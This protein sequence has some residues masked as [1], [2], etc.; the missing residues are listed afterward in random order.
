MSTIDILFRVD[1]ICK[2]YEKYDID[3]QRELNA[4]GDDAFARLLASF[5]SQIEAALQKSEKA[6]METNRVTVV[7]LNAEI[8]IIKVRLME[9]V[10]KLEKLAKKKVK[11]LTKVD[12]TSRCDMVL[13][14][15][16][17]IQAIPDGSNRSFNALGSS[18]KIK[19]DTDRIFGDEYFQESNEANQFRSEHE[20]RK[21]RQD[22]GLDI[23]SQGLDSLKNL[24][25][26]MNE[27]LDR[28]VPLMDD[29]E[30]KVDKVTSDLRNT[31]VR[32]KE[33]LTRQRE[34]NAYGD[35]AFARLLASFDY[36]IK[37]ALQKSEK[38]AM[39]T[40]RVTVVALNAEIRRIKVRLME[41]V[42]KLEK[43]AK[44]KVKGLI[45]VDL[46]SRCDM[47]LALPERIQ[48]IPDG[49][50][51]SFNAL[52]SSNKIK[53]DTNRIFGDEYFQE[54]NEANQFRSEHEMRKIRQDEGLDIISQGLD[55][56][57]NLAH[58]MNEEL[59]RQ[60]PLM[61]DI[62][63]KVDKVTSNLRNT[64]V[65][66]KETLTRVRSTRNFMI[67]II[68]ICVVLGIVSYLYN[69]LKE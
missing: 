43:L 67:D 8:R 18:N 63:D 15:P 2:K 4:Y 37:A 21:I 47:V 7:A 60:V 57:K 29:I 19:F 16:E 11:G 9:D 26:D 55:S 33:T 20:M 38:A 68:L 49:S 61:D 44:K 3:K 25:H 48:A 41:D 35:D 31:N 36:Q 24:A 56:L 62:E 22:E 14:L 51:R 58:D 40:N 32:L 50:N 17:R 46:T 65:R 66:L 42:P 13:A 69:L 45:K 23:I 52:G 59:D 54:S 30:D 34:L 28:Q 10:T 1:T 27:E 5:D 12:L 39:E 6:A 64:N 53:F